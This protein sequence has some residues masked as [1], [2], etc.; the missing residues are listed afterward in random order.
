MEEEKDTD[1]DPGPE[2]EQDIVLASLITLIARQF[3]E[4][5]MRGQ[6]LNWGG[7]LKN[8]AAIMQLPGSV[9]HYNSMRDGR[10][11]SVPQAACGQSRKRRKAK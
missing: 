3:D 8:T 11:V 10:C 5:Q 7:I 4:F 2:K 6:S 1:T 9:R